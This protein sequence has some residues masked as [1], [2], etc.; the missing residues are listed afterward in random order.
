LEVKEEA[1]ESREAKAEGLEL[2]EAREGRSADRRP[3]ALAERPA[4]LAEHRAVLAEHR[5]EAVLLRRLWLPPLSVH[6]L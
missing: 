3:V 5:V 6:P 1:L 4:A 2:P